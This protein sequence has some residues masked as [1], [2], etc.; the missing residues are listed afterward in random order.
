V[1]RKRWAEAEAAFEEAVRA[2]P[3]NGSVGMERAQ[4]FLMRSEPEKALAFFGDAILGDPN[5]SLLRRRQMLSLVAAGDLDGQRQACV[6]LLDRFGN[7]T[8]PWEAS[9]L[10]WSCALAPG[11]VAVHEAPV[12]L[13]EL[14]SQEFRAERNQLVLSAPGAVLYR[15]GRLEDAIHRL[16]EG[17]RLRK[18]ESLPR[19]WAFL[20]MAHGRLG[21]HDEARRWLDRFRSYQP[22]AD[23]NRFW[24]ELEIRLLRTEADAVV[25]YD[26]I[27][28]ADPFAH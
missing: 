9:N 11:S 10:A 25:V 4:F 5:D 23:P 22:N 27:F 19:D 16:E 24:E 28:P 1:A 6:N 3:H 21:H 12:R 26:P 13:A 18:G 17:I 14:A 15:A 7:T 20:S 8:D 2:R